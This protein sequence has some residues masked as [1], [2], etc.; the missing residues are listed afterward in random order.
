MR[1]KKA[2]SMCVCVCGVVVTCGPTGSNSLLLG[3]QQTK[4]RFSIV[5]HDAM[6]VC[7]ISATGPVKAPGASPKSCP[8]FML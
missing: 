2:S 8:R 3:E 1:H 4:M 7:F 6:F 5:S